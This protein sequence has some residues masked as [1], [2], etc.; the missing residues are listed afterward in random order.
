MQCHTPAWVNRLP[1]PAQCQ[2]GPTM[3][4]RMLVKRLDVEKRM[5]SQMERYLGGVRAPTPPSLK[6]HRR[7][8]L[9][10]AIRAARDNGMSADE[11]KHQLRNLSGC[12]RCVTSRESSTIRTS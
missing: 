8:A 12:R 11:I 6:Q 7:D 3:P 1:V 5:G 4:T 2:E 9:R 10:G